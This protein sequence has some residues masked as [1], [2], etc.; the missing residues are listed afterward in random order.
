MV[1]VVVVGGCR[2]GPDLKPSKVSWGIMLSTKQLGKPRQGALGLMA[3]PGCEG[4]ELGHYIVLEAG[5]SGCYSG[6]FR[7]Q[8]GM[9][10][11][12]SLLTSCATPAAAFFSLS[13]VGPL[14]R[15]LPS[16]PGCPEEGDLPTCF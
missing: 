14:L 10:L 5:V 15:E 4:A 11:L 7:L 16:L 1:V 3:E 6:F 8:S 13:L 9:T 12:D 2:E